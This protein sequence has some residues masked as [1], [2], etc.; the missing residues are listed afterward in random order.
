MTQRW[1]IR[2]LGAALVVGALA[3]V[4]HVLTRTPAYTRYRD[5]E[6]R[7]GDLERGNDEL[8]QRNA[9]IRREIFRLKHDLAAVEAVAR[10]E[11]GLVKPGDLVIQLDQ[12]P[13]VEDAP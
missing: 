3:L 10:D 1:W 7:L 5:M 9:L 2:L 11:L 6:D 12:R 4:P 8:R 13:R